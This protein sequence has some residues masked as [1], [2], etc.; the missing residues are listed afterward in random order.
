MTSLEKKLSSLNKCRNKL[1]PSGNRTQKVRTCVSKIET[2]LRDFI[3][4]DNVIYSDA[5]SEPLSIIVEEHAD[6][7]SAV[8]QIDNAIRATKD[9]ID[10]E[11]KARREK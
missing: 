8:T 11:E 9:A 6:F 5:V 2:A 7:H 1:E 10:A 3:K 4:S